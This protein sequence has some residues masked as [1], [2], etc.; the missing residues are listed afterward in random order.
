[1]PKLATIIILIASGLALPVY[2]VAGRNLYQH[3]VVAVDQTPSYQ[4]LATPVQLKTA[5]A[6]LFDPSVTAY[7]VDA[8]TMT[9]LFAQNQNTHRAIASITKL[10]TMI[11]V[12][13]DHKLSDKLTVGQL[14]A[15]TA[16]D[17]TL[18]LA[19]GQVFSVGDLAEAALIPSDNDAADALAIY[20]A[21]SQKAF[22]AKMNARLAQWGITGAH[23]NST[24]GLTDDDNYASAVAL[25][26]I[27]KL[28]LTNPTIARIVRL[29]TATI[30]DAAGQSYALT[31]SDELLAT[32]Q[33][34]GIKTGYTDAA[35]QCFV[36]LA[37]VNGH[38]IIT[39][40]LH[41]SDRFGDTLR[42][43]NWIQGAWQWQ[44][45]R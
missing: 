18:G 31:T 43:L 38:D 12:L 1:M 29:P 25:A 32:G 36:G 33:F 19:K 45:A 22:I 41:S 9:P 34:Y 28:A 21:G 30:S 42:L 14:P 26:K 3:H 11:I 39:V 17:E 44:Q 15:Y 16:S 13:S 8:T 27:A 23:F 20:D 6:N 10:M 37:H 5:P 35:G 40:V 24:E 7:A 2:A 4:S